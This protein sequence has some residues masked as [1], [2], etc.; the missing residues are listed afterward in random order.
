M[1]ASLWNPQ[2]GSIRTMIY[3]EHCGSTMVIGWSTFW[4][5]PT[6]GPGHGRSWNSWDLKLCDVV[7]VSPNRVFLRSRGSVDLQESTRLLWNPW[8]YWHGHSMTLEKTHTRNTAPGDPL[9]IAAVIQGSWFWFRVVRSAIGEVSREYTRLKHRSRAL[10]WV[11]SVDS[12]C[13]GWQ[14]IAMTPYLCAN[15]WGDFRSNYLPL[16]QDNFMISS[17][18][19]GLLRDESKRKAEARKDRKHP[20]ISETMY[21]D[22]E[23]E[24]I[25][26][27]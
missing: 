4:T 16:C 7:R 27:I 23:I 24:T 1:G 22:I 20:K 11:P 10:K 17:L 3:H 19:A 9:A 8:T 21:V 6:S 2:I 18:C 5:H 12:V 15:S 13:W 26:E 25:T 14:D